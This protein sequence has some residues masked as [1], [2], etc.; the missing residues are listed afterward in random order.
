M[1]LDLDSIL[2]IVIMIVVLVISGLGS[3]RKKK[4]QQEQAGAIQ[5]DDTDVF[6]PIETGVTGSRPVEPIQ[7]RA[8]T[9]TQKVQSPLNR[10]EEFI[11]GQFP[12]QI[13]MEGESLETTVDEEEMILEEIRKSREEVGPVV[14]ERKQD[15]KEEELPES[16]VQPLPPLFENVEEIKKAIIYS[17]IMTRKYK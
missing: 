8:A 5:E 7:A 9:S 3:R 11:T 15:K 1:K 17:E 4:L 13:S 2:Y 12:E 10:L 14:Q 16:E 6:N